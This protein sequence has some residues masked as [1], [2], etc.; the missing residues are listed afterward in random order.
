MPVSYDEAYEE[1]LARA[2]AG[3]V[4]LHTVELRHP[5][6][7][8]PV[9]VVNAY[10]DQTL[11]LEATAPVDGGQAVTFQAMAFQ[12]ELPGQEA[13]RLPRLKL[14][15]DGVSREI[16]GALDQAVADIA[17]VDMTYREWRASDPL[18]VHNRIGG[19]VIARARVTATRVEADCEFR[20]LAN[21]PFPR[22]RYTVAEFPG[23][24]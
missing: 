17:P 6:F 7:T 14:A 15:L 9:R 1:L 12:F 8:A 21:V 3:D 13:G 10:A 2:P 24:A 16:A 11:T 23:L 19:F 22:R 5:V 20:N 18:T 4:L